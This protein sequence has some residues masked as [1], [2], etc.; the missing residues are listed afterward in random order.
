[1][2][3]KY[4]ISFPRICGK[5]SALAGVMACSSMAQGI[6]MPDQTHSCNA[7]AI[8]PDGKMPPMNDTDAVIC[9]APGIRIGV[10][11][12]D[13]VP[14]LLFAPDIRAVAAAHAGWRGSLHGILDVVTDRLIGMGAD[15]AL[16][17]AAFGPS[18]C[19]KCYE[20][21]GELARAF[22]DAGFA[23][24]LTGRHVD[25]ERVNRLRLLRTGLA[26]NNIQASRF[27]TL[28]TAWLPSWRRSRTAQR[29]VTW[30]ELC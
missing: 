5:A 22:A 19:G 18:I 28:E 7:A 10:R 24:A 29:L 16:M 30:I 2:Y 26:E 9:L 3:R 8:G 13:C 25:L 21:D 12:A 14:V 1:M 6:A 15:P 4:E 11:T 17:Q 20:V 27:C 23:E